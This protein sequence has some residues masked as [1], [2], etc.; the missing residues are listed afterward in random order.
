MAR[1]V[2]LALAIILG[3]LAGSHVKASP[4]QPIPLVRR[5]IVPANTTTG[6]TPAAPLYT[7]PP[8]QPLINTTS[9]RTSTVLPDGIVVIGS[10]SAALTHTTISKLTAAIAT[11][12]ITTSVTV[13]TKPSFT[14][15]AAKSSAVCLASY[16]S[17][18]VSTV[19]RRL[20]SIYSFLALI[21]VSF[22]PEKGG[23]VATT[24]NTTVTGMRLSASTSE[25]IVL[26]GFPATHTRSSPQTAD[27]PALTRSNLT[28]E[29]VFSNGGLAVARTNTT[30][31]SLDQ[32]WLTIGK[33]SGTTIPLCVCV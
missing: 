32:F 7:P 5:I 19:T 23:V 24:K 4:S 33:L 16:Q 28:H 17:F 14:A 18:I 3:P 9:N 13:P 15:P 6:F 10:S 27:T 21:P 29:W 30:A 25:Y 26:V 20:A 12:T 1:S 2:W 8:S 11:A 22:H 31:C